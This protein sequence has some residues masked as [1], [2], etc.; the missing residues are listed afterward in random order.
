MWV[1]ASLVGY[2]GE[3]QVYHKTKEGVWRNYQ[4]STLGLELSAVTDLFFDSDGRAYLTSGYKDRSYRPLSERHKHYSQL[5][6]YDDGD[7]QVLCSGTERGGGY[8]VQMTSAT[9]DEE[10]QIWVGT[11][12]NGILRLEE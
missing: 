2:S 7:W 12:Y 9:I 5:V 3:T 1:V 8:D 11:K 4:Y 6:R 10:G